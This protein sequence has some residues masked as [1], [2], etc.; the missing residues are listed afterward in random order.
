MADPDNNYPGDLTIME[1]LPGYEDIQNQ[2]QIPVQT[3]VYHDQLWSILLDE[4]G[5]IGSD[6]KAITVET[7]VNATQNKK[8]LT[9]HFDTG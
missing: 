5:I 7:H 2:P 4:D 8:Q 9:G 6:G 1:I 3:A